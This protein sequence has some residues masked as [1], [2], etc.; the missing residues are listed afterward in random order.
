[1]PQMQISGGFTIC[2][3]LL[4]KLLEAEIV[5]RMTSTTRLTTPNFSS[6]E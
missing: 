5:F 2:F 1:M 6:R 3:H 4:W